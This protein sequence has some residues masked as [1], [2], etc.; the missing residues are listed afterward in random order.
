MR[1]DLAQKNFILTVALAMALVVL[2]SG[3]VSNT[4]QTT[5]TQD[6]DVY[7]GE[8]NTQKPSQQPS[9]ETTQ[10]RETCDRKAEVWE[11]SSRAMSYC[12]SNPYGTF[13]TTVCGIPVTIEC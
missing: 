4:G 13:R 8:S 6:I 9:Y 5:G 12:R 3:C 10:V 11:A 2:I 7:T 1:K